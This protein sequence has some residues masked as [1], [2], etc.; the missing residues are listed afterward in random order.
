MNSRRSMDWCTKTDCN[1][2][3]VLCDNMHDDFLQATEINKGFPGSVHLV[4]YEDL[5]LDPF[6][7][8]DKILEFVSL[9]KRSVMEKRLEQSTYSKRSEDPTMP[10]PSS[11]RVKAASN[12]RK[13]YSTKKN[14]KETVFAWRQTIPPSDVEKIQNVC[15]K[16][17]E[18]LGY[19][20]LSNIEK[21]LKNKDFS[22][23]QP[24]GS[25]T[26][27]DTINY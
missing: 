8:M 5:C 7:Q 6:N 20:S 10:Y 22:V 25:V 14:S 15:S 12:W 2:A 3:K 13:L 26:A 11:K 24:L 4:R 19:I 17:M 23:L 21:E 18:E 27:V 16:T 9:P 1:D